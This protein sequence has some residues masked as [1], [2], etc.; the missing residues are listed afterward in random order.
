MATTAAVD[1][2]LGTRTP[3]IAMLRRLQSAYVAEFDRRLRSSEFCAL[4]LAHSRNVLRH[5]GEGPRR[6]SQLVELAGVTKQAISQQLSHLET[7]GYVRIEP[8][9][10]D[11]RA[12]L[13]ALTDKGARAQQLVWQT[14]VEIEED[15]GPVLGGSERVESFRG[16]LE[17]ILG[18]LD[19]PPEGAAARSR[20]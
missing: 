3:V 16:D 18:V 13:V 6:A 1:V 9:P 7:E 8:D 19:G 10:A 5:L 2:T 4:S 12:R 20:C 15:W 17:L 11:H 14:F